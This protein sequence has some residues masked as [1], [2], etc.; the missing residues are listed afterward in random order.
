[1]VNLI[2]PESGTEDGSRRVDVTVTPSGVWGISWANHLS[3]VV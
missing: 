3:N 1:M 2:S